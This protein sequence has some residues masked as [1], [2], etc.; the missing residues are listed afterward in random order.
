MRECALPAEYRLNEKDAV[1]GSCGIRQAHQT[2]A[3]SV[4]LGPHPVRCCFRFLRGE[5]ANFDDIVNY[6][7]L[8]AAGIDTLFLDPKY[9]DRL[10]C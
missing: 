5:V 2:L 8:R 9:S 10:P 3:V 7:N 1:P 6:W 4:Y